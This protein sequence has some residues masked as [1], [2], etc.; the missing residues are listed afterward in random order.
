MCLLCEKSLVLVASVL[1]KLV[2]I[3]QLLVCLGQLFVRLGQLLVRRNQLLVREGQLLH[4]SF[5]IALGRQ[6]NITLSPSLVFQRIVLLLMHA[7]RSRT[8]L[9][10]GSAGH[11]LGW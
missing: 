6:R 11:L 8:N 5:V 4:K 3:G 7:L 1:K 10:G 9:L 2:R